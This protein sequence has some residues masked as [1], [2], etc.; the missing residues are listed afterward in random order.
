MRS[1]DSRQYVVLQ[2]GVRLQYAVF[3]ELSTKLWNLAE[4]WRGT[5]IFER[6]ER[7]YLGQMS[8]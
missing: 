8:V 2:L 3:C 7:Y 6:R 1:S 4:F 5:L